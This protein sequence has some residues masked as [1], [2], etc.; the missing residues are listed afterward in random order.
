MLDRITSIQ[1]FLAVARHGSFTEGAADLGMSRAMVSKHVKALEN[2]LGVRLFDRNTRVINLTEEGLAYRDR[3]NPV[4]EA[5]EDIETNIGDMSGKARGTLAVAAPTSFG[6]FHLSPVVA[7]YMERYPDV[8]VQLMLTDREVNLIDEG[9]DA[10]IHI[11][12]LN[13]SSL[14]ARRLSEVEMVVCAAP[15]YLAANG[16]PQRPHDLEDHNC[17]VFSEIVHRDHGVWPFGVRGQPVSI[18]VAGDLVSNLGD[19][20]RIAALAGRGVVRLPSYIVAE[21]IKGG[22]LQAILTEVE[23]QIRPIYVVYPHREFLASKV[24]TFVDYLI[25]AF[26]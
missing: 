15:D 23:P 10:A 11:R 26:K 18:R 25:A 22:R 5:L 20:L 6:L 8:N 2:Q 17:L 24:R 13:D 9:F 19:A 4:L 12:E 3:V 14:I 1:V 7:A 16:E 21:D